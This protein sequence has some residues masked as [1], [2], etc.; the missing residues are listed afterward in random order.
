MSLGFVRTIGAITCVIIGIG[1][2][3]AMTFGL[4]IEGERM[5]INTNKCLTVHVSRIINALNEDYKTY[6]AANWPIYAKS[7]GRLTPSITTSDAWV[8]MPKWMVRSK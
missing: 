3:G 2:L 6:E 8:A 7:V 5:I 1:G 4:W